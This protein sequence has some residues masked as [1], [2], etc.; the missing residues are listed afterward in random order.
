MRLGGTVPINP[1]KDD[2]FIRVIEQRSR[3][4]RGNKDAMA[5]FLKVLGNSGSYG[6]FV[7]IDPETRNKTLNLRAYSG[8]GI[9]ELDSKLP[10]VGFA[11]RLPETYNTV[12][13][14]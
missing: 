12:P 2:F 9:L 5:D 13:K 11:T 14:N 7:Q 8:E 4:K 3:H 6:L 10:S 1:Q